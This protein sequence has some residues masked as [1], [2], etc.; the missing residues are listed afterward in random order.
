MVTLYVTWTFC[1][2]VSLVRSGRGGGGEGGG[3][4]L[5]RVP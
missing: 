5:G 4:E 3:I 2:F 1:L